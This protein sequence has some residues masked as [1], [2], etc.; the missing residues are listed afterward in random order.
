M[1]HLPQYHPTQSVSKI[2]E[3]VES[4]IEEHESDVIQAFVEGWLEPSMI[5]K[6]L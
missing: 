1:D 5:D 4:I 3:V 2:Q 6:A